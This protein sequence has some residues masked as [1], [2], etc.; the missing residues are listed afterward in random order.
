MSKDSIFGDLRDLLQQ[1]KAGTQDEIKTALE[2][3]GHSVNQSKISRLLRKIGAVKTQN[4]TGQ[5]VYSLA[6][7]PAPPTAESTLHSL[8]IGINANEVG[9]VV[10]TSPGAAQL[11][12]RVIDFNKEDIDVLGSIAGDDTILVLPKSVKDIGKLV[13]DI[14][15]LFR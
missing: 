1:G 12:A 15:A 14:K 2:A 9:I 10:T 3:M 8:L 5:V 11:L 7:E 4:N 13:D 6:W